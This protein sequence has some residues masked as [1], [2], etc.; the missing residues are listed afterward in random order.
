MTWRRKFWNRRFEINSN[1][2][3][4]GEKVYEFFAHTATI[5]AAVLARQTAA[6]F[7]TGGDDCVIHLWRLMKAQPVLVL[8]ITQLLLLSL[9]ITHAYRSLSR[10]SSFS[11][12]A[13]HLHWFCRIIFHKN[14][15]WQTLSGHSSEIE[16]LC[17]DVT[18]KSLISGSRGGSIKFWDMEAAKLARGI[19]TGIFEWFFSYRASDVNNCQCFA[20]IFNPQVTAPVFHQLTCIPLEHFS[21]RHHWIPMSR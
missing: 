14:W 15:C 19:S 9:V 7:A 2:A 12:V 11:W 5:N 21:A 13:P 8:L 18:E 20:I 6:V 1:M 4:R 3:A 16:S 17:F 10:S